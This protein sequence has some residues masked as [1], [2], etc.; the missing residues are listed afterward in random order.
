MTYVVEQVEYDIGPYCKN[1]GANKFYCR[2]PYMLEV[3]GSGRNHGICTAQVFVENGIVHTIDVMFDSLDGAAFFDAMFDKYGSAGWTKENDPTMLITDLSNKTTLQVNRVT[4]NKKLH[5]YTIMAT[6][7]DI[8]FT[9][10]GPIYQGIMEIKLVDR[11]FRSGSLANNA[12]SNPPDA[13]AVST[14]EVGRC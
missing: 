14:S 7:Y 4:L 3:F 6:N 12:E 11:N 5:D 13:R 10:P 9:H 8:V 2:N 1:Q